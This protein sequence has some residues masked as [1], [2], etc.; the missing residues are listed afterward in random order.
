MLEV[1][2][3]RV[4]YGKN[5]VLRGVNLTVNGEKV[6]LI[7]PNGSGKS[8]L[9]KAALGLAPIAGGKI[10]V[11]GSEV[12]DAKEVLKVSTNLEEVYGLLSLSVRDLISMFSELKGVGN[13]RAF[14]LI[15]EFELEDVLDK[16]LYHL[17]TGQKKMVCNIMAIGSNP[18]LLLL[19]EPFESVDQSRRRRLIDLLN[20]MK[21]E[22]L[23]ST[24]ELD[25]LRYFSGWKLYF[26]LEGKVW[27]KFDA[28][29]LDR[30][31][32]SRGKVEGS[33]SVMETS[34]GIFS[35]TLDRGDVK[36]SSATS[37]SSL[38]ERVAE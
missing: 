29:M 6:L 7:G 35:V 28:S 10:F 32:I 12:R 33:I 1:H 36:V 22:V 34:L 15:R 16:K 27:G 3:L 25:L 30:L 2:D 9:F 14:E 17:S 24:H 5:T 8:T 38:L 4:Q 26:I 21:A 19:D 18:E 11:F 13:A 37:L 20:Q 31:Y 23:M